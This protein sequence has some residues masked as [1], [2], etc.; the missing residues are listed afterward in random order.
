M[1]KVSFFNSQLSAR[2]PS[3]DATAISLGFFSHISQNVT[4]YILSGCQRKQNISYQT[5]LE[6][7]KNIHSNAGLAGHR[8]TNNPDVQRKNLTDSSFIE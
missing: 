1:L 8:K 5:Y 2:Y 6:Y 3:Y 7:Q 4:F